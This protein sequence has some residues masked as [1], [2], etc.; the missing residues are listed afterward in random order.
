ML[1]WGLIGPGRIARQFAEAL[2]ATH[3]ELHAVHSSNAE[4]A[5]TFANTYKA[6]LHFTDLQAFLAC[7]E[8]DVVY[9]ANPHRFHHDSVEQVLCA[10]KPVLCEKPLTVTEAQAKRLT[11][12]AK[13]KNV[14]LMEALWTRF[15]PAWQQTKQWIEDGRIGD[16]QYLQSSFG[17]PVPRDPNDRLLNPELAGGVLLDM[18]VYNVS[19]SQFVMQTEPDRIISDV[20][21]GETGVDERT[22]VILG[23]GDVVS[24]FTCGFTTTYDNAFSIHGTTGV[25]RVPSMFWAATRAELHPNE[26]AVDV[27]EQPH[28]RNGFEYQIQE[29]EQCLAEGQLQSNIIPWADTLTTLRIMDTVLQR[30]GVRYPFLS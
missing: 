10:G 25:I 30:A 28:W 23:F 18:G 6:P 12:L 11:D 13:E 24:Q 9:I 17:F 3:S 4:R 1:R 5:E 29:V 20:F 19:M 26:G 22:S 16:I 8:I 15:L 2:P 27:F 7:E 21:V 14:F